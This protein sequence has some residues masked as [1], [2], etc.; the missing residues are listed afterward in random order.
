MLTYGAPGPFR[1]GYGAGLP[2]CRY[3]LAVKE[4]TQTGL[5]ARFRVVFWALTAGVIGLYLYGLVTRVYNPLQLGALSF[6][7]L[8]LIVLF[9]IHEVRLRRE[10]N[11][12]PPH[13]YDHADRE[14]RGW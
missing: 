13:P 4:F 6:L 7:C 1:T 8:G 5:F 3:A 9:A 2:E 14:R 12:H 10:L 11:R